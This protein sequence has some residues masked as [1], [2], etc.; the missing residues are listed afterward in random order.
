MPDLL[1]VDQPP[2]DQE[3]QPRHGRL[4]YLLVPFQPSPDAMAGATGAPNAYALQSVPWVMYF[5]GDIS[6]HGTYWH[7]L[8]GYRQSRGCVNLTISDARWVFEWMNETDQRD[9]EGGQDGLGSRRSRASSTR[10]PR[11]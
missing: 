3:E 2:S 5:D 9:A 10:P 11:R 6:L 4:G 7:N 1:E 8:F